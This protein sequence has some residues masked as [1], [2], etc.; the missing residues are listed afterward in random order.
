MQR[1]GA[2][3]GRFGPVE[4]DNAPSGQT[5]DTECEIEGDR[6][7]RNDVYSAEVLVAETHNGTTTERLFD[8]SYSCF[9]R[10]LPVNELIFGDH[11]ASPRTLKRDHN[12]I[13]GSRGIS[14]DYLE[15][16]SESTPIEDT[17]G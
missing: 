10:L 3:A 1:K 6:S 2:L 7:G 14:P 5:T 8:L 15:Q 4:L 13:P 16:T 9:Q 11:R 17:T 12:L